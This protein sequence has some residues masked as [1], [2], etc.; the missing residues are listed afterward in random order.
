LLTELRRRGDDPAQAG[1]PPVGTPGPA[2]ALSLPEL[3]Q[4]CGQAFRR[5]D[6][7]A[8]VQCFQNAYALYSFEAVMVGLI[9]PVMLAIG[10]DWAASRLPVAVE[11]FASQQTLRQLWGM[12]SAAGQPWRPGTLV[13]GCAPGERHEIGLL[14]VVVRLRWRGWDVKYLGPELSLERLEEVLRQLQ[15]RLL[16]FSATRTE[17]A[18]HLLGLALKLADVIPLPMVLFGGQGFAGSAAQALPGG[19]VVHTGPEDFL[20]LVERLAAAEPGREQHDTPG[21]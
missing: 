14:M 19:M 10:D 5:L 11:H 12:F 1:A 18:Q 20:P 13:A 2:L 9:Q 21:V 16:L 15:P 3:A 4:A 6:E 7:A 8:V 17:T